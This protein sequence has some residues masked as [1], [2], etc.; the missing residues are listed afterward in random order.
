M[1]VCKECCVGV[2]GD[3]GKCKGRD[4]HVCVCVEGEMGLCVDGAVVCGEWD[5]CVCV[6][7]E[8]SVMSLCVCSCLWRDWCVCVEGET[9]ELFLCGET[10]VGLWREEQGCGCCVCR[11]MGFGCVH[12][13]VQK[14]LVHSSFCDLPLLCSVLLNVLTSLLINAKLIFLFHLIIV[15]SLVASLFYASK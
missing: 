5:G 7:R 8:R 4:T 11:E 13:R 15:F 12:L 3:T 2:E 10:E 9:R 1:C 14:Y 6:C